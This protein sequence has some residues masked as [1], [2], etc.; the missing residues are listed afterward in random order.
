MAL[1][2]PYFGAFLISGQPQLD[3][4]DSIHILSPLYYY[5]YHYHYDYC[6]YCYCYCYC[7]LLVVVLLYIPIFPT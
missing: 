5:Y 7:Y 1:I 4:A 2:G 6:C 3:I